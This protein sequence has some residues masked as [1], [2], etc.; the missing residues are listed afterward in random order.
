MFI[1]TEND[2]GSHRNTHNIN[3]QPKAHQ[4]NENTFIKFKVFGQIKNICFKTY[5]FKKKEGETVLYAD[6]YGIIYISS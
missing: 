1:N 5:E 6:L 2:I 4:Q 3:I